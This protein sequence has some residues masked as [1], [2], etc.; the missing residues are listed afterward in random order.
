MWWDTITTSH[1]QGN[2][3]SFLSKATWSVYRTDSNKV[4]TF[5]SSDSSN[6]CEAVDAAIDQEQIMLGKAPKITLIDTMVMVN[7]IPCKIVRVKWKS[8]SYDYYFNAGTAKIDPTLYSKYVYEGWA[9]FVKLS[10]ALPLKIVK[11]T[12]GVM[13]VSMT[14]IKLDP[15]PISDSLFNIPALSY[16]QDLNALPMPN[17]KYY[18]FK[19]P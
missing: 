16:D 12:K 10:G 14:M 4:F 19:R 5:Q 3:Y 7:A 2:M 6:I 17:K 13:S 9:E 15:K 8:G 11:T 18:Q 1:K